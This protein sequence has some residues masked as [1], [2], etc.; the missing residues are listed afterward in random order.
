MTDEKLGRLASALAAGHGLTKEGG[1]R[2]DAAR[3][4]REVMGRLTDD[5]VARISELIDIYKKS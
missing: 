5:D 4:L 3:K 2:P 1:L